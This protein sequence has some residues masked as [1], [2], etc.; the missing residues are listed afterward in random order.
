MLIDFVAKHNPRRG[1]PRTSVIVIEQEGGGSPEYARKY[2]QNELEDFG[3]PVVLKKPKGSKYQRARPL[4]RDIQHGKTKLNKDG[5]YMDD[6][7]QESIE[8]DPEGKG[9]SPN[10]VDSASLAR[11][12]LH[13]KV[14]G[15]KTRFI[16]GRRIG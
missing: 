9:K 2:F 15:S 6:F 13:E 11:N 1:S 3:I 14:M 16:K 10:L 12:Y 7:I 5:N 8:L 4:M